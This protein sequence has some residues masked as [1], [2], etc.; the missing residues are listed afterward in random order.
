MLYALITKIV[1]LYRHRPSDNIRVS[2]ANKWPCRKA[3]P[4]TT[5]EFAEASK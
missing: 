4:N 5:E 3:E 2:S 1:N